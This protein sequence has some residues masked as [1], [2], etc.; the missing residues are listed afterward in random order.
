VSPQAS[1]VHFGLHHPEQ[2][3]TELAGCVKAGSP[4][5]Y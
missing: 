1:L 3:I 5:F 4:F 2:P